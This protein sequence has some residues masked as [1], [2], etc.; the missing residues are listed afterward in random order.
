MPPP[1]TETQR[2]VDAA[3]KK[4]DRILELEGKRRTMELSLKSS[5][6]II[7]REV[8][9]NK[10]LEADVHVLFERV[11]ELTVEVAY[12]RGAANDAADQFNHSQSALS[13]ETQRLANMDC[14]FNEVTAQ[15]DKLSGMVKSYARDYHALANGGKHSHHTYTDCPDPVCTYTHKALAACKQGVKP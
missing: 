3:A 12:F 15:R 9:K 4:H 1:D 13:A 10:E 6:K 2:M 14:Q 7:D 8:A 5:V 11:K